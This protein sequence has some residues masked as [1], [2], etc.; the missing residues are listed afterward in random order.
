MASAVAGWSPVII[1][2]RMPAARHSA[3]AVRASGRGGS[4]SPTNPINVSPCSNALGVDGHHIF[5]PIALGHRQHA[6]TLRGPRLRSRQRLVATGAAGATWEHRLGRTFDV[7][8]PALAVGVQSG[9]ALAVRIERPFV[10]PRSAPLERGDIQ[11]RVLRRLQHRGFGRIADPTFGAAEASLHSTRAVHSASSGT[12]KA[13]CRSSRM[14]LSVS[15]PVLSEQMTLTE[16]SVSTLGNRRTSAF[17]PISRR[18]PSASNTVTTAGSAS[19]MAATA[20]LMAVSAI[21]SIGSPRSTPM[22]KTRAQIAST[23]IDS[24][25]PNAA[26]RCCSGV[27]RLW[28]APSSVAT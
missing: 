4:M 22:A 28:A 17:T 18:A 9:H 19:G 25:L 2:G 3:T 13:R 20:R 23:T 26:S 15:V 5:M 8:A 10:S 12:S 21:S 16:P 24:R 14:R 27:A 7:G 1:T 6:H 11:A